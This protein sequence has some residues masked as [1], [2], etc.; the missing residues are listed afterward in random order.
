ML[1]LQPRR[2]RHGHQAGLSAAGA[3]ATPGHQSGR[4]R[5]RGPLPAGAG[6]VRDADRSRTPDPLRLG[7]A[8]RR[9]PRAR[10]AASSKASTS[11]RAAWTTRRASATSSPR[12]CWSASNRPAQGERGS[13]RHQEVTAVVR[14]RLLGAAVG[15]HP[16]PPRRVRARVPGKGVALAAAASACA[17][18]HGRAR[19]RRCADTWSSRGPA[20]RCGGTGQPAAAGLPRLPRVGPGDAH[21]ERWWPGFLPGI[22]DGETVRVPHKGDAGVRGGGPGD[23]YVKVH[24]EADAVFTR[25]GDDLH[26]TVPVA[27]A[28]GG[29]RRADRA[30]RPGRAG[31]RPH[32]AGHAVGAAF[33]AAR[34]RRA[35]DAHGRPRRSD[36]GGAA[37]AAGRARRTVEGAAA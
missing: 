16:Q 14:G 17:M 15:A 3:A 11:R 21:G 5:G 13:D 20:R 22:A 1:G 18:C 25:Q 26:V 19:S 34:P 32:P 2:D 24:V 6:G 36:R 37:D 9:R 12:C 7:P 8:A 30:R 4:P 33:P 10:G 28:R 27:R 29:A 35:V 23:L 31:A